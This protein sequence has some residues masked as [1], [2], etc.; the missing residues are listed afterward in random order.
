MHFN[1]Y[2]D[3]NTFTLQAIR[4][5]IIELFLSFFANVAVQPNVIDVRI[6]INVLISQNV[7]SAQYNVGMLRVLCG[8]D[9]Y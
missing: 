2:P 4:G 8:K 6:K 7:L 1:I 3:F 5:T 9:A